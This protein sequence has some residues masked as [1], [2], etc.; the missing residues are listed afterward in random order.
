MDFPSKIKFSYRGQSVSMK[1]KYPAGDLDIMAL[2]L[3]DRDRRYFTSIA[4][5]SLPGHKL[6]RERC[7]KD[8]DESRK[9]KME[10]E[11]PEVAEIYYQAC[12][13]IDRHNRCRQD[14][15]CLAKKFEV[16]EWSSRVNTA[17]LSMC[18]VDAW[19]RGC[20]TRVHEAQDAP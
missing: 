6:Y 3:L 7:S 8:G 20:Y 10:I 11:T 5:T 1:Q 17:I 19:M 16:K 13:Q 9:V 12:S 2:M 4:D 18:I 15:S 14:D